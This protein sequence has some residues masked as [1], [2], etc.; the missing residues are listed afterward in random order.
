MNELAMIQRALK[1]RQ[2]RD[3]L[4]YERWYLNL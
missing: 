4:L 3:K 2:K 1:A